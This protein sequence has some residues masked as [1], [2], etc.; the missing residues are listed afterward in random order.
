MHVLSA[1]FSE[2]NILD[3][4]P[5]LAMVALKTHLT[6]RLGKAFAHV[7]SFCI[8][9]QQFSHKQYIR[10]EEK[11]KMPRYDFVVTTGKVVS[12]IMSILLCMLAS[13]DLIMVFLSQHTR[14][15][16]KFPKY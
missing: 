4:R 1:F 3:A 7:K 8:R 15:D 5:F 11:F 10:N 2:S 6:L 13:K 16:V 14:L 9:V 12:Q